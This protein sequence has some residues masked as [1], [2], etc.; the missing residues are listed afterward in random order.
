MRL[1]RLRSMGIEEIAGRGLQAGSQLAERAALAARRPEPARRGFLRHLATGPGT[2]AARARLE[3]GDVEG[4]AHLL[5]EGFRDGLPG[6]FF[7]GPGADG[8]AAFLAERLPGARAALLEEAA[9][10]SRGRFDLLGYRG[11][12]FGDPPDWHL[13]AVSGTRAPLVHWSRIDP[14]DPNV[15]GDSKV[16]W[17][18]NRHQWMVRLGQAYRLT[19]D[20]TYAGRFAACLG[21]WLADNPPGVGINWASSLEVALRLVAWCW[22]LALFH[23]SPSLTPAFFLDVLGAIHAHARHVERFLSHYFSP[24]THLTG[25]GLG[26]FYAGVL[27]PE[28]GAAPRWRTLGARI[29][30]EQ[31][32]RQV[33]PDG[34]HFERSTCYQRYTVEIYLHF[35]IL[36]AR[37]GIEVAPAVGS[38]LRRLLDALRAL[39]LPDGTSPPIGD[40]DGGWL[41]PL[42]RRE[43]GDPRGIFSIAAGFLGRPE[44]AWAAGGVAPEAIWLLG[45]PN[46]ATHGGAGVPS[47][48]AAPPSGLLPDGGYAVLRGGWG[49]R[50][51]LLILDVGPLGCPVSAGHGH[52]DL[53]GIQCAAFGEPF[54]VD[55]GTGCY[56]ADR[57]WRDHFRSTAAHSTVLVD[58]LD[59]AVPAG[60]F[61]WKT[62]PEARLRRFASTP[63]FDLADAEHAAYGGLRDPVR[64]RRRALFVG[65]RYFVI[66]D[67][68]FGA[69]E[70]DVL[71]SFQMAPRRVTL[72]GGSWARAIGTGSHGLLVRPFAAVP[73]RAEVHE[74]R[75]APIAGWVSPD[76][77]AR[78]PAP[79]LSYHARARFPLRLVTLLLPVEDGTAPLPAVA[80]IVGE[81]GRPEGLVI[82]RGRGDAESVRLLEDGAVVG[83]P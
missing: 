21:D 83:R 31:I 52:A 45:P 62:R 33:L 74:G 5:L 22:A 37:H 17:E 82:R 55:P 78:H 80:P 59:Q 56:A 18:L 53:L 61:A 12:S 7:P 11:L 75:T 60:P 19:G 77:G 30:E 70:H 49:P 41:L 26:L 38:G 39:R 64:H 63:A 43:P 46:P 25:E 32:D 54:I 24:N 35:V 76:Y 79:R 8:T 1:G 42:A 72:E 67:D 9:S 50:E 58:G 47:A 10:I 65:G 14:L 81:G 51:H 16:I 69:A 36:A 23:R 71:L 68:L 34:V 15:V 20:E 27:W 3:A 2:A 44:D 40:A 66:V 73:L 6:R 4:A 57:S 28:L 13:D 48:P 29:L